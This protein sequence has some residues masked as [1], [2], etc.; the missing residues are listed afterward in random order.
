MIINYFF[1]NYPHFFEGFL[2]HTAPENEKL[3]PEDAEF[4]DVIHAA[5]LWIGTDE[6]VGHVDFYPNSGK[7]HQP[8]CEDED[9]GLLCSHVRAHKLFA[10]SI[11]SD[12]GFYSVQCQSWEMFEV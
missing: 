9:L 7:A 10:E 3:S 12:I 5:G 2:F 8:G 6:R 1:V 11:T 4:V